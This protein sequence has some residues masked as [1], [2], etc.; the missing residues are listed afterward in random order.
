MR[1]VNTFVLIESEVDRA[2]PKLAT[3]SSKRDAEEELDQESSKSHEPD[4][5]LCCT[6]DILEHI[7]R[8]GDSCILSTKQKYE[9]SYPSVQLQIQL[10][11]LVFGFLDAISRRESCWEITVI[12][13]ILVL[14]L[15]ETS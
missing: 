5:Q 15:Q 8:H 6:C 4:G 7:D 13:S 12:F 11:I 2:V 9:F 10:H 3:G 14:T 1:K